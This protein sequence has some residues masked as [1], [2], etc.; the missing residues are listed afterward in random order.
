MIYLATANPQLGV[1]HCTPQSTPF[2]SDLDDKALPREGLIETMT[3][4]TSKESGPARCLM[5][6]YMYPSF[7]R[8]ASSIQLAKHR[9]VSYRDI[10]VVAVFGGCRL[11]FAATIAAIPC[12]FESGR[13]L[14][15]KLQVA[16]LFGKIR[17]STTIAVT[18]KTSKVLPRRVCRVVGGVPSEMECMRT[19]AVV[20]CG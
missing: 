9:Q 5:P 15:K 14:M 13:S 12:C 7:T 3:L 16:F 11:V 18:S 1:L 17:L 2:A 8:S 20:G 10:A 6:S 4:P 19:L